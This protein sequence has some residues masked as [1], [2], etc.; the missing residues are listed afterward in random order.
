MVTISRTQ[1]ARLVFALLLCNGAILCGCSNSNLATKDD[2]SSLQDDISK[3]RNSIADLRIEV[4]QNQ[5][6]FYGSQLGDVDKWLSSSRLNITELKTRVDS[7]KTIQS[8]SLSQDPSS[9][10]HPLQVRAEDGDDSTIIGYTATGLPI[11]EG[12]KGG[13][14]HWSKNGKKVYEKH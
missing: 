11:H 4:T 14:Y 12:P 13:H 5:I 6:G 9:N 10:A 7:L 8:K 3:L 1:V 2:I